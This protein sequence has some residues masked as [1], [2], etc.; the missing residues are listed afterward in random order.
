MKHLLLLSIACLLAPSVSAQIQASTKQECNRRCV[1]MNPQNPKKVL[2]EQK[3]KQIRD[4]RQTETDSQKIKAL[5]QAESDE[6]DRYQD[7]LENTC[8]EICKDNPAE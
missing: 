5:L 2:H 6:I 1:S 7:T 8:R 4:K 3:L